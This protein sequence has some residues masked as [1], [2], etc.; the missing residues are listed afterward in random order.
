M[1]VF[2]I[3]TRC[4][5]M[6][7]FLLIICT[8]FT[9]GQAYSQTEIDIT[10]DSDADGL[11]LVEG[12]SS[13][14]SILLQIPETD[15]TV[16]LLPSLSG[17]ATPGTD[18]SHGFSD[19]IT[20]DSGVT[21][22]R[23]PIAVIAD[24]EAEDRETIDVTI[25]NQNGDRIGALSLLILD[26][27]EITIEPANVEVCQGE[28]VELSTVLP[29]N[30]TW[31]LGNDTVIASEVS[32]MAN[33][34]TNI[35][36]FT[37]LGDCVAED[38]VDILLRAGIRFNEGDT[39]Y[40]CLGEQAPVSVDII[41]NP[42][43]DYQW[44]PM[45]SALSILTDQTIQV[46]TDVTR[47]YYLSF[48][49]DMCSV[50]DSVVIRVDSLPEL[51]IA[52]IP[53][54]EEYCPGETVTLFSRY[55]NPLEFPDVTFNWAYEFGS[56]L[57]SDTLL[58]FTFTTVDTAWYIRETTN[59]ACSRK[60]SVLLNVINPPLELTVTDTTVCPNNPVKVEI[61][62]P[63][64]FDE[65]MWMP[66][67]GLSCTDCPDPTIRTPSSMTYSV[68]AESMGCPASASVQIN[69]FP[70]DLIRVVPDTVV[71]PGEPVALRALEAAEYDDLSWEGTGLSCRNCD[72]PTASPLASTLYIVL[73]TKPD[74][75]LGQGSIQ[76][77]THTIPRVLAITSDPMS[78]VEI[79]TPITLTASTAPD[80]S[81]TGSFTWFVNGM[82]LSETGPEIMTTVP[83][84]GENTFKVEVL[85][86]EGCMSMGETIIIGNPPN[87]KIPSA[88]TPTGDDLNDRFK[89]LIFGGIRLAE[90]KI[91]NRWG[92]L[93]Y[94]DTNPEGWDGRQNGKDAP[95]DVYAYSAVLEFL[96]GSTRT[97]RG[98]V[99]LIR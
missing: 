17:S 82:E 12:C 60:D 95:A 21:E 29:G 2:L 8:L 53:E 35:K 88:F 68:S 93:V 85:S 66:E 24:S 97:V 14:D 44:A 3:R 43:G 87:F 19:Q 91:F 48:Q 49:N 26:N 84:E 23:I 75:C 99:N 30:Y 59:N 25:S 58:N 51:P 98:E 94:D 56:P 61:K 16:I 54:K 15:S 38:D 28:T 90:F 46:N 5:L 10:L 78:P 34:E 22:I 20:F 74:G 42:A 36:V 45:D 64:N 27:L 6:K 4:D 31:I 92:Q 39:V 55:L 11:F 80:V 96:D 69:I 65:I 72:D 83:S 62:D 32:F 18:Y 13:G 1:Y 63:D 7:K 86:P 41:G 76:L 50:M 81:A 77:G 37:T 40:I 33:E 47:T 89:V 71:C 79:G 57:S 9:V 67:Q 73:G 70:P 52:V